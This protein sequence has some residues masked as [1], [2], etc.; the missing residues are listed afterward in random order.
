MY[1]YP[2]YGL[3]LLF[4]LPG[5]LLG[6]WAQWSL[7]GTFARYARVPTSSGV[8]GAQ[9][10]QRL[11]SA[12]SL[13]IGVRG[14]P[15]QLTDFYD[16]R[17]KTINLSQSSVSNS[18]ASVAVVAH[19]LGHAVQDAQGYAPLRMR[20]AIV[21]AVQLGAWVGP[22]MFLGGL[23]LNSQGLALIG[24]IA[25]SAAAVFALVTLP[26]EFDAS[27]RA[28]VLLRTN[29]ILQPQELPAAHKVLQAAALTYVAAAL[30]ALGTLLYYFALFTGSRR[31]N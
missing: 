12:E 30:Q 27:R 18:V 25:F 6:L 17:S 10:A 7:R 14:T 15:G 23:Y 26:V 1:Y 22:L 2:G 13:R 8:T 24:L 21:P 11:I 19:E 31:R 28:L 16:P 5:L 20:A 3:Y 9:T 4:A 29:G